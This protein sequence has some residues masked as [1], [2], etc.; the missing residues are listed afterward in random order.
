MIV[1]RVCHIGP[2]ETQGDAEQDLSEIEMGH[3]AG[4]NARRDT[5]ILDGAIA[6][7]NSGFAGPVRG[8]R[9]RRSAAPGLRG[10]RFNGN[11]HKLPG[12]ADGLHNQW[13]KV[14]ANSTK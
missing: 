8:R 14:V 9:C 3:S 7:D 12:T 10:L 5:L 11:A 1:L 2:R 6:D 13:V 4:S